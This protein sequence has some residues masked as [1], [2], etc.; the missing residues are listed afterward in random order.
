[1]L[2]LE[3]EQL[4]VLIRL[5]ELLELYQMAWE[6][7]LHLADEVTDR[8]NVVLNRERDGAHF[9]DQRRLPD[10]NKIAVQES[11]DDN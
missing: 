7:R 5:E 11:T 3:V 8:Q 1:M 6:V 9:T 2:I 10:V 4:E